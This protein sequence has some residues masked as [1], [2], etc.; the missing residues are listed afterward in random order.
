MMM[1]IIGLVHFILLVA[2]MIVF[3]P[4]NRGVT[5]EYKRLFVRNLPKFAL[6]S[7][8]IP[9]YIIIYIFLG[10]S[11][12]YIDSFNDKKIVFFLI[13]IY[14]VII[15]LS[16]FMIVKKELENVSNELINTKALFIPS[17]YLFL[18][19]SSVILSATF[20]DISNRILDFSKGE[21]HIVTVSSAG[22]SND[23]Y[24]VIKPSIY[25]KTRL[26]VSI[27]SYNKVKSLAKIVK[28]SNNSN[29]NN[30]IMTKEVK[31]KAYV[32][33]GLYG[34]RYIGSNVEVL[35]N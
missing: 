27:F 33:N 17:I 10:A 26:S 21:E 22:R 9:V 3:S 4:L 6:I 29:D 14:T 15:L 16:L 30:Y 12:N 11:M 23:H 1:E 20:I 28:D 2:S 7:V 8:I 34:I 19:T 24:L 31:I 32:Y 25:K 5:K 35:N 18:Y 13:I